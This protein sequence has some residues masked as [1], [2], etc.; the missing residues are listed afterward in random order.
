MQTFK[1]ALALDVKMVVPETFLQEMRKSAADEDAST[2]LKLT[3][4]AHPEDDDAFIL[5]VLKNGL[6]RHVRDSVIQLTRETGLGG[7]FAPVS[8]EV[9]N[10]DHELDSVA[11]PFE[12]ELAVLP[13]DVDL[14]NHTL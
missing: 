3:Q 2:F 4:E 7:T 12:D 1:L 9:I 5:A 8:V 13:E 6:R 10:T 11:V 14:E